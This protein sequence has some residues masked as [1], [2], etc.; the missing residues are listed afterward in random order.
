MDGKTEIGSILVINKPV[1]PLQREKTGR[2]HITSSHLQHHFI[3]MAADS[4]LSAQP[5]VHCNHP[6]HQQEQ[7]RKYLCGQVLSLQTTQQG[8]KRFKDRSA[9]FERQYRSATILS[10]TRADDRPPAHRFCPAPPG[11]SPLLRTG[12]LQP[13]LPAAATGIAP[14]CGTLFY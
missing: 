14:F 12:S 2:W 3:Q 6:L 11:T 1:L 8:R 9:G 10:R 7:A 13:V 5:A 4:R